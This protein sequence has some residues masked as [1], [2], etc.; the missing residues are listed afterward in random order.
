MLPSS[1]FRKIL[2]WLVPSWATFLKVLMKP[3]F[4]RIFTISSLSLEAGMSTFSNFA[5]LA[6]RI[7][8]SMS[9]MGSDSSSLSPYQLDLV[10]PGILPS[11]ASFRKQ[12]LHIWNLRM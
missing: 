12:I 3:S 6:L 1:Y 4:F 5:R 11:L 2:I 7:L 10:T 8:V 9:A